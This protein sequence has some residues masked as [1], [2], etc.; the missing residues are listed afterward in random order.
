M[1]N[2][3]IRRNLDVTAK[4]MKYDDAIRAGKTPAE[5]ADLFRRKHLAD[6]N[7]A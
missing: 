2:D 7:I 4:T 3:A 1:V 6:G 5:A